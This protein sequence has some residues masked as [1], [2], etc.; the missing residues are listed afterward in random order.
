LHQSVLLQEFLEFSGSLIETPVLWD[1]TLGA[2]GHTIEWLK[3]NPHGRACCSDQDPAMLEIAR[4][5]LARENLLDR[6]TLKHESFSGNPFFKQGPFDIILMDLGI[7]SYH[8]DEL[9]RGISFRDIGLLDMRMNIEEGIPLYQWLRKASFD[10]I[11]NVI[12]Q[13]GEESHGNKIARKIIEQRET[14]ENLTAKWLNEICISAYSQSPGKYV[15]NPGVKTF[16][17]FRIFINKEL[18]KLKAS[19]EF[20]PDLLKPG[21]KLII[22]S[23]HSLED[24][25]VKQTFKGLE[26]IKNTD[27]LAKSEYSLGN[28]RVLTKKPVI[29]SSDEEASNPRSRSAKMRVLQRI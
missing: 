25:I 24:R 6:V 13:F 9:N 10:E 22:I 20:I 17:A 1:A 11:R 5:A 15:K 14:T 28:F 18:E 4:V 2:A 19:L 29:P 21:G 26:Q 3:K 27:P 8:L 23:F 16:Q 12:F 7:S